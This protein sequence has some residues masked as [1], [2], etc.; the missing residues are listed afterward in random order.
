MFESMFSFQEKG[1]TVP[2]T[3]A[4]FGNCIAAS[5]PLT[6]AHSLE[7]GSIKKGHKCLLVGT[8]AGFA[9]GSVLIQI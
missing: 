6:L 5:L 1:I 7:N 9:I 8:S 2:S 3:L 4:D